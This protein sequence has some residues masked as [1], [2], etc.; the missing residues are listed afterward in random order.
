MRTGSTRHRH[1]VCGEVREH[2]YEPFREAAESAPQFGDRRSYQMDPP[3]G[4]EAMREI[5]LNLRRRG[6]DHGE[7]TLA[8]LDQSRMRGGGSMCR[9]RRIT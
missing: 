1:E 4:R 5:E 6:Y 2:V 7:A 8:Y 3:N 9:S